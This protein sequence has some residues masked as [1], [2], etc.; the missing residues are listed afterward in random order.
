[1]TYDQWKTDSGYAERTSEEDRGEPR[2]CEATSSALRDAVT[3]GFI[4]FLRRLVST[5]RVMAGRVG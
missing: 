1:M 5:L 2:R 3:D 4:V